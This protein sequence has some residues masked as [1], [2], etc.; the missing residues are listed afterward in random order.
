[1]GQHGSTGKFVLCDGVLRGLLGVKQGA[2]DRS[3]SHRVIRLAQ[4]PPFSG[5]KIASLLIAFKYFA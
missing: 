2:R 5:V 1:M 3:I 4:L